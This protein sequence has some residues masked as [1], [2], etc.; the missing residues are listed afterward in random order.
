MHGFPSDAPVVAPLSRPGSCR[1]QDSDLIDNR[2]P[3]GRDS[4][5]ARAMEP[6]VT[7]GAWT[8]RCD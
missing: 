5:I 2:V 1:W 4:A 8:P 7:C 3:F 6:R